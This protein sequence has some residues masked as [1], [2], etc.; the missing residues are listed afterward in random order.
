MPGVRSNLASLLDD[1]ARCG[2]SIAIVAPRGLRQRR[3]AYADLATLARRFAADLAKRGLA[4]GDRVILCGENGA[5]WVGAFFGCVLRGVLPVP[6]DFASS[7]EFLGRVE[8]EVSPKLITGDSAKL[9]A[10]SSVTPFIAFEDFD[11]KL[12]AQTAGVVDGLVESDPLQIIF[13][14]GT[15][16]DPKGVVH[17]HKNV[18]ASLEP[19]ERE[20]RK[21]LK[22][23]RFFHPIRILHTLPLSH[24]FGQFMGLWIPA[25]L[26]AEV[27]YEPRLVASE[28]VERIHEQHISVLAA[29]PRVLD[30]MQTYAVERFPDLGARVERAADTKALARWWRFRDVH[31]LLGF[32]F[33]AFVCGG[34]ALSPGG[35]QFWSRLGF[36]VVQGYGMTETTALVSL[37]H[38]FHPAQ[39]TIG[40]VLPGRE[41][42]LSDEGEVLVRGDTISNTTWQRGK[43]QRQDSE[44]LAT[45]DLAEFDADG[46]LRFRGRKKDVIVTASGLN[47]Y[48]ED[49]E[50]ALN[51]QAGIKLSSVI[52][53]AAEHG[54]EP[55][56]ALVMHS[57]SDPRT[58][59]EEANRGLADFQ[60]IRRWLVWP[61]PDLPRTSTG[62]ILKREIAARVASGDVSPETPAE[63]LDSLGRVELQAKLEQKYGISLSDQVIQEVQTPADVPRLLTHA[64]AAESSH[65]YPRWPWNPVMQ[66]LRGIF[67]ECIAMPLVRFLTK[68]RLKIQV[69]NWPTSPVLIVCNHVT[70]YDVPFILYALPG[71]I[72]R[73][74]AVAMSAEMLLDF[75]HARKQGNWFLNLLAPAAYLLITG[76]FNVFPLPQFSG[77]RR[78]FRHAG[79]A[80]DRGYSVIVFPEGR[81][82][83]DGKPQPFKAGAGLL[84]KELRTAALPVRLDG[85][86]EIKAQR[87]RWFRTG[88]ISVSVGEPLPPDTAQPPADLTERLR[89][90]VFDQ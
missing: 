88:T 86:G 84:W 74:A 58:A 89:H 31:H 77:F 49:L 19:I 34:A 40:Q 30:L 61:E 9:Q 62:K 39:G 5:E 32:K 46:N 57:D 59:V 51:R 52:E 35:E 26:A 71:H 66:V 67:L 75:R 73:H 72:R 25:L 68:P 11:G 55:L 38:P 83:D 28:V 53:V 47:I 60:Q 12:T 45:G 33:W 29:V 70:S 41:V 44:W 81:R 80:M 82:S 23:E 6:V 16:G 17:T 13:T 48:P 15:T 85:L 27:H 42:R 7:L 79:E 36:V 50:A 69:Q 37:N 18:L 56:A 78:S 63:T 2:D 65:I 24:V 3:I 4:K 90:A 87:G 22:Y 21:Y 64:P 43:L 54:P 10:F 20:M 8:S 1:F 76:L 14:S